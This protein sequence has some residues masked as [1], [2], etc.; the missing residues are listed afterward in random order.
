MSPQFAQHFDPIFV[1]VLQVI[2][3]VDAGGQPS[4]QQIQRLLNDQ[5][6]RAERELSR[7]SGEAWDLAKF[8]VASWIDETFIRLEQWDEHRWWSTNSLTWQHYKSAEYHTDFFVRAQD[9]ADIADGDDALEVFYI[10]VMLGFRGLY[11]DGAEQDTE[12]LRMATT[13][14]GLP[15]DLDTWASWVSTVIKE[16]NAARA[17]GKALD[18]PERVI[19]TARPVW[20]TLVLLWPWLLALLLAGWNYVEY[21]QNL[22][23]N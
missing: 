18:A 10:C 2:E 22:L 4:A 21:S 7:L 17:S 15:P 9:A 1:R 23:G 12:G 6:R 3:T 16:R 19:R 8:A 20:G 5:L 14:F 13:K 11:G